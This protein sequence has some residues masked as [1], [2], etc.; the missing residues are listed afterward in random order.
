[1]TTNE[2]GAQCV[3]CTNVLVDGYTTQNTGDDALAFFSYQPPADPVSGIFP[4]PIPSTG[5]VKNVTIHDGF[6]R[7]ILLWTTPNVVVDPSC[8]V[9]DC[10]ILEHASVN[11]ATTLYLRQMTTQPDFDRQVLIDNFV[12]AIRSAANGGTSATDIFSK[13][14]WLLLLKSHASQAALIDLI[15]PTHDA[16]V[17]GGANWNLDQS[18]DGNGIDGSIR[19]NFFGTPNYTQNS[20]C[21]FAYNI[22]ALVN[23]NLG[24]CGGRSAAPLTVAEIVP[25]NNGNMSTLANDG[26]VDT[27][28]VTTS[29]AGFYL[30][31]RTDANTKNVYKDGVLLSTHTTAS[32]AIPTAI[33]AL[34]NG[35]TFSTAQLALFGYG[36]ALLPAE[37]TTLNTAAMA[38][39]TAF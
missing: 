4:P 37:I 25:F 18:F 15:S 31:N 11:P 2:G 30:W 12:V 14:D 22:N 13:L 33:L 36:A 28:A 26:T 27:D 20:A 10:P 1:M 9:V 32:T 3:G 23:E 8:V 16:V 17:S 21:L 5:L 24:M 29:P 7:G 39:V 34:S 6:A 38:F 19:T 35:G